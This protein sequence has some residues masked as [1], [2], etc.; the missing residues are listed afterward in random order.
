MLVLNNAAPQNG[1][2][3]LSAHSS[4]APKSVLKQRDMYMNKFVDNIRYP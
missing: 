2:F 3:L 1:E 4:A